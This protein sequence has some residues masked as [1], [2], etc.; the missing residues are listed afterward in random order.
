[1]TS[2][3]KISIDAFKTVTKAIAYSPNLDLMANQLAQLLVGALEIKACA[4]LVFDL[5]TRNLGRLASYGLSAQYLTKGP[6]LGDKSTAAN[7]KGESVI[8][9]VVQNDSRIQYPDE[10][11]KEGIISLVSIPIVV[12]ED[13]LGALRL[14]HHEV[15]EIS[16]QDLDSLQLLAVFIGLAMTH[17]SLVGAITSI[18]EVIHTGLPRSILSR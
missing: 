3:T 17:V 10:A 6:L 2:E 16:E 12:S 11:K 5:E 7:L 15:W 14:Y 18:E 4:I 1:M 8:I 13:V 9:N